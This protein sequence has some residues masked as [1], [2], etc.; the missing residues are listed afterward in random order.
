MVAG[1][2]RAKNGYWHMII[3]YY[4]EMG[5]RKERSFTTHLKTKGNRRRAEEM[6]YEKRRKFTAELDIRR[7]A[8]GVYVDAYLEH[9]LELI[10][11]AVSPTTFKAYSLIAR[12]SICPYF[13]KMDLP[14]C[15][16]EPKHIT[17]YYDSLLKKGLSTTTVRRHH[18]NIHKALGC[19]VMD[20]LL[21]ENPA[22]RVVPP[23]VAP[24]TA[25]YY[26]KAEC[27]QLLAAVQG[28]DIE[29]PVSLALLL[30]LRRS[31]VLGLKWEA[32]DFDYH[33]VHI[34]HTVNEVTGG[35]V[36][37]DVTKRKSSHRTLPLSPSVEQLLMSRRMESGYICLNAD[38]ELLKPSRLTSKF[39]AL[40]RENNLREI[41]YHDLRHTCAALLIA[42]RMPLI[43]V[44][45]WLGHSS[46]AITADL[47]GHLEFISKEQCAS[48]LEDAIFTKGTHAN[49]I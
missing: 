29:L 33:T 35:I 32:I 11:P 20:G 48:I 24:Y 18:A 19:A 37:R 1:H 47:Y 40:L 8:K 13:H 28:S 42:A 38:N 3:S 43:D 30:G 5:K 10:Q 25:S 34:S 12:N 14:I 41:R 6:L 49:A 23:K 44:S 17:T 46:I 9:W 22:N 4:D 45:R 26:S 27:Q 7:N 39:K 21:L 16:L 36:A 31:E 2:L 15:N